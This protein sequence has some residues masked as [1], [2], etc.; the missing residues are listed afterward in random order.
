MCTM[1]SMISQEHD[2]H[3]DRSM[4]NTGI[5]QI[6]GQ[7]TCTQAEREEHLA[8]NITYSNCMYFTNV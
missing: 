8:W 2:N 6:M 3:M 4:D 5:A 1:Y 7:K